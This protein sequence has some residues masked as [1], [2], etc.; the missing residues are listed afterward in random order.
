MTSRTTPNYAIVRIL[1]A[2][3][4]S[5]PRAD[6]GSGNLGYGL[7]LIDLNDFDWSGDS[8]FDQ[9][10]I[11]VNE[12]TLPAAAQALQSRCVADLNVDP[13]GF[14][15]LSPQGTWLGSGRDLGLQPNEPV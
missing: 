5:M 13:V 3:T 4:Q 14:P 9:A 11:V 2:V 8:I 10:K 7:A 12:P 6:T 1:T 15:L